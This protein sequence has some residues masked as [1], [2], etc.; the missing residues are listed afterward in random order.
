MLESLG[1]TDRTRVF[2]HYGLAGALTAALGS[3]AAS[4][5]G[6]L[7]PLG[8]DRLAAMQ[9]MFVLYGLLGKAGRMLYARLPSRPPAPAIR[10]TAAL[11][12]SRKIVF[13]LFSRFR[14]SERL[15]LTPPS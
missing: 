12:P 8:L 13:K 2:A 10:K 3:L 11:G 9:G 6:L 5:P 15:A 14:R 7:A 1:N 4:I